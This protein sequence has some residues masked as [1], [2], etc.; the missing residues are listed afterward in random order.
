VIGSICGIKRNTACIG[1]TR[2]IKTKER[3]T[4]GDQEGCRLDL[5]PAPDE[6]C[7]T[8]RK[9]APCMDKFGSMDKCGSI[10][11]QLW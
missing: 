5:K 11:Y 3:K 4:N 9:Y 10:D 7:N 6:S 8:T 1:G 2:I